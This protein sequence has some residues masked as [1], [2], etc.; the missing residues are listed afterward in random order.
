MH[1]P[2]VA[3]RSALRKR[4]GSVLL[5]ALLAAAPL[6]AQNHLG[7]IAG[8]TS[9][10]LARHINGVDT[11]TGAH[12]GLVLG[13][14]LAAELTP[15]FHFGPELLFVQKGGS[16]GGITDKVS[17]LEVPLLWRWNIATADSPKLQPFLTAGPTVSLK[18]GCSVV[19]SGQ[20]TPCSTVDKNGLFATSDVSLLAGGG[21]AR[22]KWRAGL[23]YEVGVLNAEASSTG[24]D[25]TRMR[26]IYFTIGYSR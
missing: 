10:T 26:T 1:R 11:T 15:H 20:S 25:H 12:I 18:V 7:V 2:P 13:V 6:S 23:R 8:V 19:A 4:A 3:A 17:Y 24:T 9:G 21:V 22:G 14:T 5:L 16:L